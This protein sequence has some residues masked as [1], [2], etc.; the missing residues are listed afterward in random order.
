MQY[1]L[2]KAYLWAGT[3]ISEIGLAKELFSMVWSH[4]SSSDPA[5]RMGDELFRVN[6]LIYV[7]RSVQM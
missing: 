2:I 7:L 1:E 3:T 6:V 4:S 5:S